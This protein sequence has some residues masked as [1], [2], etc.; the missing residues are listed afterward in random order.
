[1]L[2]YD[3]LVIATWSSLLGDVPFT[4]LTSTEGMK[5]GLHALQAQI[6]K[7]KKI[8]IAGGD[9]TG[10]EVAFEHGT[11]KEIVLVGEYT[12]SSLIMYVCG[13]DL[14]VTSGATVL[15]TVIPSVQKIALQYLHNLNVN[16][17]LNTKVVNASKT[18]DAK[19]ILELSDVEK[20][21]ADLYISTI[22]IEPNSSFVPEK[23]LN[24]KGFVFVN[25]FLKVN[26]VEN[27]WAIGDVSDR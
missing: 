3:F 8:V 10:A 27:V 1:M 14:Q 5:E 22:G 13:S 18:S 11:K 4:T 9:A 21:S 17:K 15:E 24:N 26:G 2:K 19:Q 16:V 6:E 25:S 7:A 20:L 23:Y 12:H